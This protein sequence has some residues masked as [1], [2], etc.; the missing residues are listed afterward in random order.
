[1]FV[2]YDSVKTVAPLVSPTITAS[3][4]TTFCQGGSVILTSSSATGNS[5][6]TGAI[7]Q[8]IPVNSTATVSLTVSQSGCKDSTTKSITVNPTPTITVNS[9]SICDGSSTTLTASGASTYTWLPT[10]G[11]NNPNTGT[12]TA[13][14]TAPTV[15]TV[16]G[17]DANSCTSSSTSTVTVL[18]APSQVPAVNPDTLYYCLY[19]TTSSLTATASGGATLNWFDANGNPLAGAPTPTTTML[20]TTTY[21]VTQSIGTCSSGRDSIKVIVVTRP[22]A[23]FT[24][25]SVSGDILAGQTVTFTPNQASAPYLVYSWN[26]GET[27][28]LTN[29]STVYS[30]THAYDNQATYCPSLVVTSQLTGCKDSSTTC[31]EVL[32]GIGVTIPNVFSPNGDNINDVFSV[33]TSGISNLT[34]SIYDR[35][36]LKLYDWNGTAGFWDGTDMKNGK[37][38]S[39]GTYYYVIEATDIKHKNHKYQGYL[40]LIK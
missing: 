18:P 13:N 39:D 10:T 22:T 5:W 29:T 34:C 4:A 28:S 27:N 40:Q 17:T 19:Q 31:I 1:M 20:G 23:V 8:T 35:W 14:P 33:K 16:S 38:V 12:V 15:Y 32:N 26:F 3:G 30:P 6:S 37:T 36:G 9:A 7:T 2:Q 24:T 25:N 21:Y 11:I